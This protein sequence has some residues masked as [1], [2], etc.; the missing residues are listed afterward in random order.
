MIQCCGLILENEVE[1]NLGNEMQTGDI[2]FVGLILTI[3]HEPNV[4]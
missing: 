3:R 2:G 1:K 4:L